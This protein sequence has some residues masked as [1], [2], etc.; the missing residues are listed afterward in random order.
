[1]KKQQLLQRKFYLLLINLSTNTLNN[2]QL[3]LGLTQNYLVI[4]FLKNE[5]SL[6][7]PQM[8]A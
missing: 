3:Q 5:C 8:H 6:L 1:M 2:S 4:F 7:S